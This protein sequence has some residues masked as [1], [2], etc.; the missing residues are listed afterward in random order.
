MIRNKTNHKP[1]HLSGIINATGLISLVLAVVLNLTTGVALAA[2][3]AASAPGLGAAATFSVLGKA[4]VTNTGPSVLSGNVGADSSITG[5]PPGSA[6]GSV[7]A[8]A[9]NGPEADASTADLAL[10]AQT[11]AAA[12][13]GPNLT[14]VTLVPGV[15]NVGS[16]LLPGQLTLDGPG[17]YIFLASALT[18][19]GNVNMINGASACNVFW[20]VT[21]AATITGGS[22]VGTIIAG[23]SVTFGDAARL[24]GRAIALTG[25][26]TLINNSISGPSCSAGAGATATPSNRQPTATK[27]F[28]TPA[29]G[30][31]AVPDILPVTGADLTGGDALGSRLWIQFGLG[32]LG[33]CLLL[34]GFTL[35]HKQ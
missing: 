13:A 32:L 8:P 34:V 25:S 19:S 9:V 2:P 11:S 4:G 29:P 27:S 3:Q 21:S 28:G 33:L 24:D 26:V 31:T 14:G 5:F 18:A 22:F 10:T 17:V 12:S 1:G 20:H 35:R 6:A 30:V 15:Y 16:A 23:T 7:L